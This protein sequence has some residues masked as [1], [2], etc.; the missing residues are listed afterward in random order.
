MNLKNFSI[1]KKLGLGFGIIILIF[2]IASG[3]AFNTLNDNISQ[4]RKISR[5]HNPS[6]DRLEELHNMI[7]ESKLLIKNWV[8]IEKKSGTT[9]KKK[10]ISLHET[11]YPALIKEIAPLT[12]NWTQEE[13]ESFTKIRTS[14]EDTLFN[15]H[16]EVMSTLNNFSSYDDPQVMFEIIP[17][18]E[19]GGKTI[20]TT[21][22]ILN[23]LDELATNQREQAESAR[24]VM[25]ASLSN[26][27]I[28]IVAISLILIIIGILIAVVIIRT[29]TRPVNKT[30]Q[31]AEEIS[32]G[33]LNARIDIDTND[34]TG[35][36]IRALRKMR[37]N[38]YNIVVQIKE[39]TN[40][41]VESSNYISDNSQSISQGANEQASSFE[42]VSSSMEEMASNIQQNANNAKQTEKTAQK[43]AEGMQKMGKA[44]KNNLS[45][46]QNI[47]EKINIIN[48]I[49]FQTNILA[50]NA[51]VEAA[52]AGEYGRGFSVVASEVK[53]LADRSKGAADEIIELSH[54]TTSDTKQTTK[55]IDEFLP[56]VEQT[57]RLVQDISAASQEQQSG[58]QQVNNSVQQMNE[59]TQRNASSS[60][61]L[62]NN[63]QN[64]AQKAQELKEAVKYF[65]TNSE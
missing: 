34:E 56:E 16:Q 4:V 48:D 46:I 8:F 11:K 19:Q 12:E 1:A 20:K 51:A 9:D 65:Q 54:S 62:A 26:F 17:M 25:N 28:F 39:T 63:S 45:A 5:V 36:L 60:E 18:V 24:S 59:V 10:L 43:A 15:Q 32:S 58:V 50:I 22:R 7:T 30:I 2:L 3:L 42:E 41:F 21:E 14:I 13:R 53:K 61:E 37:D 57:S 6:V 29:I 23:D 55:L 64:L 38:I 44:A 33:D 31:F 52:R 27:K 49:A 47:A 35:R 40:Q